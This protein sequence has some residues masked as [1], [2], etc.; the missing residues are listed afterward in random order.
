MRLDLAQHQAR[1]AIE[2]RGL[3]LGDRAAERDGRDHRTFMH[4][5]E[6]RGCAR[7]AEHVEHRQVEGDG[8][9]LSDDV[10]LVDAKLAYRPFDKGDGAEMR[11]HH[12]LRLAG[13]A[14]R[15]KDIGWACGIEAVGSARQAT[16][17]VSGEGRPPADRRDQQILGNVLGRRRRIAAK[18]PLQIALGGDESGR[19]TIGDDLAPAPCRHRVV[20]R[21]VAGIQHQRPEQAGIERKGFRR[22][23]ADAVAR[24]DA[25]A[26]QQGG[27]PQGLVEIVVI[28]VDSGRIG[29]GRAFAPQARGVEQ[30]G[31]EMPAHVGSPSEA[32]RMTFCRSEVPE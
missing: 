14:R 31:R 3:G 22:R 32:A 12:A 1:H 6:L 4:W 20:D 19:R 27:H 5:R 8:R 25:G 9:D 29:A 10:V 30:I 26:P 21:H 24:L 18:Q 11:M 23:D 28:G 7:R 13:R 16:Q 2:H 17:S 15:V